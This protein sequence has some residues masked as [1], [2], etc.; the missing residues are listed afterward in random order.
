MASRWRGGNL[1]QEIKTIRLSARKQVI[2]VFAA[3][4]CAIVVIWFLRRKKGISSSKRGKYEQTS[5]SELSVQQIGTPANTNAPAGSQRNP[6]RNA[7]NASGHVTREASVRSVLTLPAYRHNPN[8]NEQVLGREGERG[9][10]DTVV[11]CPTAED[12]EAMRDEEMEALYQVRVE[13]R[14]QLAQREE[15]RRMREEARRRGDMVALAELR[16]QGRSSVS[17]S[18]AVDE[19]RQAHVQAKERRQRAVSSVSYHE[20]GIARHDGTRIRAGS[21]D[22]ERIGLLS[23]AASM[24]APSTHT[25]HEHPQPPPSMHQRERSTSSILSL[26]SESG[27]PSPGLS[28][29]GL[30]RSGAATPRMSNSHTFAGSSPEIIVESDLGE[31]GMLPTQSPPDYE[32]V[33]LDDVRSG[34]NTPAFN[35]PPPNYPGPGPT[36]EWERRLSAHSANTRAS[37]DLADR[38]GGDGDLST[39]S[40]ENSD[41]RRGAR[42]SVQSS[43]RG[44]GGVPRLPSL[45][46]GSLP[47]IVIEP[48]DSGSS[49]NE[50]R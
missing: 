16:A 14:Q 12:I 25:T 39:T 42:T 8:E 41:D 19:L 50:R 44:V 27:L 32:E 2:G 3:L 6:H 40:A 34:S 22:S 10:V 20:L 26:D 1:L 23:D 11:E 24:T 18:N 35:E 17:N 47:Q 46:I 33:S 15:R 31:I 49:G 43:A 5:G 13:R 7:S 9:G 38:V 29:G 37:A 48:G 28:T 30:P 21:T 4:I 45:R 36:S